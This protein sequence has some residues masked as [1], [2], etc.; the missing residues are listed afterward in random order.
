[1]L[2]GLAYSLAVPC[3]PA[4]ADSAGAARAQLEAAMRAMGGAD[5]L[6][7][8]AALDYR[9]VGTRMMVE[10]SER[11]TGPYYIDHFRL[12]EIRDLRRLRT[13]IESADEGYAGDKWWLQQTEAATGTTILNDDVAANV[14][15]AKVTFGGGYQV[16]R[17]EEEFAFGPERVL[18]TAAAASDLHALADVELHGVRHHVLD[19]TW[20]GAP[21][22]LTLSAATDLPWSIRWTRAYPYQTF[23]NPWGDVTT[24]LTYNAWTLEPYGIS[25]PRE[26]TYTRVGLPDEQF[27]I[28]GLTL[29]PV[30]DDAALTVPAD[31]YAAHHGK[32]RLVDDVPLGLG[33][34]GS[35]RELAPGILFYPGGWNLTFV[36]QPGGTFVIEAP[37]STG[38]TQRAFEAALKQYGAPLAGVITTSDSWPHIAGVRQAV[39]RGMPVYALDLNVPILTRLVR[40]PHRQH[41]DL[42]AQHPLAPHFRIVTRDTFVGSGDNRLEI[43]PYRTATGE[44]QMMVYFPAHRLLYTSDLFSED[45]AGGWFT[46]QYL[47]EMVGAVEREH[48]AVDTLYGMH[49]GPTPYQHVLDYLQRFTT[50]I[51]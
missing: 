5:K 42:L 34:D 43:V 4:R 28:V 17:N 16:Q 47:H 7:A 6:N 46:P 14:S 30:L 3:T 44:R 26:W 8:I 39:A 2:L 45:G 31:I 32:L 13:R 49:Y 29:N 15:G 51:R 20:N 10:Q 23:L 38:Y 1:M 18:Q 37:W 22:E 35:P 25:Y 21:C 27:A 19:F 12:H 33:G 50:P 40:A 9:A 48:L 24:T 11:P 36:K 41:P